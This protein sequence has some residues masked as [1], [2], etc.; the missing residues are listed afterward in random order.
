MKV[1]YTFRGMDHTQ[2][3][4]DYVAK[5]VVKLEKYLGKEDPD[6]T[7]FHVTLE[8]QAKHNVYKFD[9][10]IKS[11]NFDVIVKKE[12]SEMYP[13]IDE[14]IRTMEIDLRRA[15]EKLLDSIQKRDKLKL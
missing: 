2:A 10:R 11:P 12:G 7:F 4:E 3:I 14:A 1:N 6:A 15:K 8:G 9:I 5:N 13:L